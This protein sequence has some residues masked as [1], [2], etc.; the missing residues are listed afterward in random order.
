MNKTF[1]ERLTE[2]RKESGISVEDAAKAAGITAEVWRDIED[3][4]KSPT[5]S[6]LWLI[7]NA[8]DVQPKDLLEWK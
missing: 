3:N 8:I 7:S 4:K 1:G 6:G 2:L 5:F